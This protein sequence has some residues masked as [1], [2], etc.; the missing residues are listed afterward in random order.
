MARP[1]A[2]PTVQLALQ[3]LIKRLIPAPPAQLG[4]MLQELIVFAMEASQAVFVILVRPEISTM[5]RPVFCAQ[6]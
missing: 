1:A 5:E 4:I 3:M 2:K 6:A